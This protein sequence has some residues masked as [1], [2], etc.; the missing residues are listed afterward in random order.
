VLWRQNRLTV[1]LIPQTGKRP[2]SFQMATTWAIAV[3]ALVAALLAVVTVLVHNNRLLRADIAALQEVKQTNHLQQEEL[4]TMAQEAAQTQEKMNALQ[5]LEQQIRDLTGQEAPPKTSR[6]DSGAPTP[7][8]SRGRGGPGGRTQNM[9]SIPTLS[10][11]IPPDV[12]AYLFTPR[13]VPQGDLLHPAQVTSIAP[14]RTMATRTLMEAQLAEMD[15][16]AESLS[17]GKETIAD[18]MDY[19]AHR[20][21]GLPVEEPEFTDRFG[22]RWSPFGLGRQF[23]AGL[24]MAQQRGTPISAT[25]A[26]IVTYAGWKDGGYGYAVVVDHGYGFETLYAHM[27]DWNVKV[28]QE[29]RR[30]ALLGWV[31]STGDS[32]GPHVHYEVHIDDTPVDPVKYLD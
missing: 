11:M 8:F 17:Q 20:P 9:E 7:A 21:S 29:V 30:G 18:R 15:R 19:L 14:S 22:W 3:G 27:S 1:I 6:G 26:G 24:D 4:E 13:V 32:T 23:H 12:S 16:L 10:A 5:R 31:G 2:L 28:G 25:G